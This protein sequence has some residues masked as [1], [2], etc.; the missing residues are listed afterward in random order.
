[1]SSLLGSSE[2]IDQR[3]MEAARA[4]FFSNGGTEKIISRCGRFTDLTKDQAFDALSIAGDEWRADQEAEA[5]F[6]RLGMVHDFRKAVTRPG[7]SWGI[8]AVSA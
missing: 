5:E 4:A 1:M 8:T 2:C 3:V 7:V 6:H